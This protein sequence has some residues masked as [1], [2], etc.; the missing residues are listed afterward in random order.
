MREGRRRI[1]FDL[2]WL[3]RFVW[4]NPYTGSANFDAEAASES[5]EFRALLNEVWEAGYS[6]GFVDGDGDSYVETASTSPY[7]KQ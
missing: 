5:E 4:R 7:R 6:A 1:V 2:S 3:R